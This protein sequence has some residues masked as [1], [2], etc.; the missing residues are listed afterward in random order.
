M[1]NE[2]LQVIAEAAKEGAFQAVLISQK[3]WLNIKEAAQYLGVSETFVYKACESGRLTCRYAKIDDELKGK[4]LISKAELDK[5]PERS[6]EQAN[7][8]RIISQIAGDY[9]DDIV[10]KII[11]D[12]NK[13]NK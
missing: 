11:S 12:E 1:T 4:M 6:K 5:F 3:P 13:K 8:S 7:L 10:K 9:S 2:E